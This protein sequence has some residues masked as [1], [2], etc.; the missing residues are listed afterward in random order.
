MGCLVSP[1]GTGPGAG[2]TSRSGEAR[3]PD[4]G[5]RRR[6][7]DRTRPRP[8]A[9]TS[10]RRCSTA[11]PPDMRIAQEEIFGPV[12]AVIPFDDEADAVRLANDSPYGLSGSRLEPRHRPGAAGR[13]GH[14]VGRHQ[15]QLQLVGPHRGAV[16]G[17]EAVGHRARA[18]A[19]TRWSTTPS[20]RTSTSTCPEGSRS[21][22]RDRRRR[23]RGARRQLASAAAR[24]DTRRAGGRSHRRVLAHLALGLVRL[25]HPDLDEPPPRRAGRRAAR[26]VLA[27]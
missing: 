2:T 23:A 16:R 12:V 27:V 15:R 20:S 25:Q 21:G 3:A 7:H 19:C 26:R 22:R 24:R 9:P 5:H 8:A 6:A 4:A 11:R 18:R 13:Q 10:R 17:H 14:P 1:S